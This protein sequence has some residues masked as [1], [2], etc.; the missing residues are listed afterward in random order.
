[1]VQHGLVAIAVANAKA[2]RHDQAPPLKDS[3]Q[4]IIAYPVLIGFNPTE[5]VSTLVT[6]LPQRVYLGVNQLSGTLPASWSEL[7][8][9]EALFLR[10]N[11]LKGTLPQVG[12]LVF[13]VFLWGWV[14]M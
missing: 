14:G 11:T 7:R 1:M 3:A 13:L 4:C 9:L 10:S 12:C 2:S 6:H 5:A 8:G